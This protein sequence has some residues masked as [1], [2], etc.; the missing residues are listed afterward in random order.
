MSDDVDAEA[1]APVEPVY[2]PQSLGTAFADRIV[3]LTY[4]TEVVRFYFA[5]YDSSVN[6]VGI[7]QQNLVAQVVM[8]LTGFVGAALFFEEMMARLKDQGVVTD[9]IIQQVRPIGEK[10]AD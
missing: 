4:S 9:E 5:R 3:N 6:S 1:S 8:P 2:P 10:V 7:S